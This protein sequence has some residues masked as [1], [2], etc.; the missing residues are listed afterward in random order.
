MSH[1]AGA[2]HAHAPRTRRRPAV[3]ARA[4]AL[5]AFVLACAGW[6]S[7]RAQEL[8]PRAYSPAPVGA[9]Y[10]IAGYQR[11]DG[12]LVFDP[13]VPLTD[14]TAGI[15]G[16]SLGAGHAY[17]LAGRQANLTFVL[18]YAHGTIEGNVGE[19]RR[20]AY[21]SGLADVR[22][23]GSVL[24]WNGPALSP[25]AFAKRKP[26]PLLG[27]SLTVVAPTGQYDPT[28]L[29]NVGT[30]RWAAKPE[31]GYTQPLG[32]WQVELYAGVW[33]FADNDDFFGGQRKEQSPITSLQGHLIYNFRPGLWIAADV[34]HYSGGRTT[35]N[36]VRKADLQE[37]IRAGLT[38]ALALGH[39]HSL[40]LSW[41]KGAVTRIGGDF[42]T[43][44]IGWQYLWL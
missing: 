15:D 43:F 1:E 2:E 9:S 32:S 13:S 30:N 28:K 17:D 5:A 22:I 14:V 38:G 35:L 36:G 24:L 31:I 29:V 26:A 10:V 11:S 12:E 41:S 33:L 44:G 40:K 16:L 3:D 19:D 8:E 20:S 6:S 18:P 7:A 27:A 21:R 34:T 42:T 4:V 37:N 23:R 25:A 39:G